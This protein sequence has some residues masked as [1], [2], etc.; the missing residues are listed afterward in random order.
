M[1]LLGTVRE[2]PAPNIAI[3]SRDGV[4]EKGEAARIECRSPGYH[5]GS[6]F[7]LKR[8][9]E[10][11]YQ[12]H[13]TVP[14]GEDTAT[15][16]FVNLTMKQQGNYRCFYSKKVSGIWKTS[17]LSNTVQIIVRDNSMEPQSTETPGIKENIWTLTGIVA[18]GVVLI[19]IITVTVWYICRQKSKAR[20]HRNDAANLWTTF[21]DNISNPQAV[22]NRSSF[23]FSQDL[24]CPRDED[25]GIAY[26]ANH[27]TEF[28]NDT[29]LSPRGLNKKPYFV[30]FREQ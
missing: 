6:T 11:R 30:T 29:Q 19:L 2:L 28:L 4:Y 14:D 10:E 7:Y 24:Q 27:S 22:N 8:D 21:G 5:L 25:E 20:E 26:Y 3:D 15:F 12:L 16:D 23:R 9:G 17:T 1:F 18:G 13:N